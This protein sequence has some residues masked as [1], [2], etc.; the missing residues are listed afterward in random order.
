MVRFE[1]LYQ[2]LCGSANAHKASTFSGHLGAAL[3][4]G[5]F[6]GEDHPDLPL[7][8]YQGI[9][10]E[11][12]R[13]IK[14]EES[15]W[16]NQKKAG[17]TI[18]QL[19][20]PLPQEKHNQQLIEG[21]P[22]ELEKTIGKLRQS[23]HNVIFASLVLRAILDHKEYATPT[24]IDGCRKLIRGFN[25]IVP[26]QGYYGKKV[27]W[28]KGHLVEIPES[29]STSLPTY[30][31]EKEMV[32]LVLEELISTAHLQKQGFGGLWHIINHTAG[33]IELRRLGYEQLS[34]KGYAAHRQHLLLWRTL[35]DLKDE[36]EKKKPSLYSP[37]SVDYW[38][39]K[40][41][42]DQA[43]LTHRIKT[44]FGFSV[45]LGAW[46]TR[47]AKGLKTKQLAEKAFLQLMG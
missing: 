39:Q 36:L 42:R 32:Q 3:L 43:R 4:A 31:T 7:E 38:K 44:M 46:E 6:Y 27:G 11:L 30:Q 26:G 13:I 25:T 2:G 12:D 34:L 28:K 1:Y 21:I 33:L 15:I 35:P 17:I 5:Y 10:K 47:N 19:F 37:S 9:E 16:F 18:P 24:L 22:M 40:L 20:R 29:I 23:G 8:V 41:K 14:G 45:L